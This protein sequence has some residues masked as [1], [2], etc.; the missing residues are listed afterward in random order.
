MRLSSLMSAY[1]LPSARQASGNRSRSLILSSI[2][3]H[4]SY[5]ALAFF[6]VGCSTPNLR[7]FADGAS[8]FSASVK[9][10]NASVEVLLSEVAQKNSKN[11]KF[12][13]LLE[14]YK[15][16]A[17]TFNDMAGLAAGYSTAL[18]DLGAAGESGADAA[19]QILG[20]VK[21]F[22]SFLGVSTGVVNL[23][24]DL[25]TSAAGQAIKKSAELWTRIEAHD[26][27]LEVMRD[28]DEAVQELAEALAEVYGPPYMQ[29]GKAKL[30]PFDKIVRNLS[31]EKRNLLKTEVGRAKL[32]FYEE[33]SAFL[34]KQ[35]YGEAAKSLKDEDDSAAERVFDEV[36]TILQER[37]RIAGEIAEY[38]SSVQAVLDWESRQLHTSYLIAD[39]AQAWAAEHKRLLSWFK[40]CG[41]RRFLQGGC[42]QFSAATLNALA[43]EVQALVKGER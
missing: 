31:L 28:A 14:S 43:T 36:T 11:A 23:P 20:T 33:A 3:R 7:P 35:A 5:V 42:G 40:S 12:R 16:S 27:L 13:E 32:K 15:K 22:G 24:I 29:A 30:R 25:A 17:K 2:A 19:E 38:H 41:G 26:K 37:E 39:T 10:T 8:S 4:F 1:G 6:V 18:V 34:E 21:E 9:T